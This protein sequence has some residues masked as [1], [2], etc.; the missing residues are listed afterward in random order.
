MTKE[1]I[2]TIL[3]TLQSSMQNLALEKKKLWW[4]KYMRNVISFRG[5]GIPQ[6][7]DLQKTWY[8]EYLEDL[9]YEEQIEIAIEFLR[10]ELAEDKL[11]GILLFQNYLYDKMPLEYMLKQ[12]KKIFDEKLIYDWNICDWFCVRVLNNTI[13]HYG[14]DA[15]LQISSWRHEEYLWNARAS[16]VAF[17]GL[18]SSQEYYKDIKDN[19]LTLIQREE[20][21]AKTSVGWILHDIYKV[22]EKFVFDFV[23]ENLSYFSLESLK[24][25]IKYCDDEVKKNYLK[26]FKEI[27]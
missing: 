8:K 22:D 1:T 15:A 2:Q 26:K 11:A 7:R 16:V 24:N 17:I 10:C 6:I 12:Y 27:I 21:F 18:T 25:A 23:D 4:E 13:K 5:V 20:R 14:S 3:E 19:C 9:P